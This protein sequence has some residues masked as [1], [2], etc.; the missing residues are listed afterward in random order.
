MHRFYQ[1]L[2]T[3]RAH[4]AA[5]R[6]TGIPISCWGYWL[7]YSYPQASPS[8]IAALSLNNTNSTTITNN[9]V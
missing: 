7:S 2:L 9:S 4:L 1:I 3:Y 8:W 5:A 6:V